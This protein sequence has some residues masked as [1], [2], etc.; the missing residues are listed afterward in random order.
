MDIKITE[1][2]YDWKTNKRNPYKHYTVTGENE[3]D[4]FKKIYS[5]YVRPLRYCNGYSIT[6]DDPALDEH[7]R[8][9]EQHGVTV[10]LFY[11]NATVD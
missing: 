11:G 8:E 7:F 4:C 5:Y 10:E 9:W 1:R 2:I 3:V 6:L